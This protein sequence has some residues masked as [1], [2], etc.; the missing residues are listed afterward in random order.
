M[1]G[2]ILRVSFVGDENPVSAKRNEKGGNIMKRA[3]ILM[4]IVSLLVASYA[5]PGFSQ[6][7]YQ[8]LLEWGSRGPGVNEFD[9]PI[10]VTTD[11]SGNVYVADRGNNRIQKFDSDGNFISTFDFGVTN[12]SGFTNTPI[13]ISAVS[14]G[15]VYAVVSVASITF[16]TG[17]PPVTYIYKFDSNGN[18]FT[19]WSI[20]GTIEAMAVDS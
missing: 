15:N 12:A 6:E 3:N 5:I 20:S 18:F 13:Q 1:Q 17:P 2:A 19:R 11:S 9:F 8:Y 14:T 16:I 4:V 7:T 10:A